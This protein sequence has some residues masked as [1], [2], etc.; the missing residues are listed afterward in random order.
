MN[1]LPGWPGFLPRWLWY[2][3]VW[4]ALTLVFGSQLY[5]SGYAPWPTTIWLEGIHWLS[6][7][8]CAPGVFWL[9]RRL[10]GGEHTWKRYVIG[11]LPGALIVSIVQPFLIESINF[12]KDLV[13]WWL[14]MADSPP[15]PLCWRTLHR[16]NRPSPTVSAFRKIIER[17]SRYSA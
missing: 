10:Y 12:A 8:I 15:V 2:V 4:V 3:A 5:W 7:G 17:S 14:A 1:T 13:Q 11:L 9:C 6:W 16:A